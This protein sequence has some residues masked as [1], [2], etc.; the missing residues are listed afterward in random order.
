MPAV[1]KD[2]KI[3]MIDFNLQQK[4]FGMGTQIVIKDAD[5]LEDVRDS[6]FEISKH[7]IELMIKAGANVIISTGGIDET[8]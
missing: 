6:E 4:T 5:K 8:A 7:H 2:A 3:A 1:I